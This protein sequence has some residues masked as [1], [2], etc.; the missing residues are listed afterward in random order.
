MIQVDDL[1]RPQ[2]DILKA[3]H[4]IFPTISKEKITRQFCKDVEEARQV[5]GNY[6]DKGE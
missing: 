3:L 2:Q 1:N 6:Q 4:G 5:F